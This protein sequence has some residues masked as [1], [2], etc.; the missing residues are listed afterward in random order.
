[1]VTLHLSEAKT[2][3]EVAA[4]TC[5]PEHPVYREGQGFVPAGRL[6]LGSQIVTRAGPALVVKGIEWGHQAGGYTVYNLMVE[7]DH[8]YFVGTANGGLWVH[9]T[10][11][12]MRDAFNKVRGDFWKNE[13]ETNPG[14]YSPSDLGRMKEGKAPIG[15]DGYP[16]ELHHRVPL[17][18]GG[19]NDFSNLDI[20][21]RTD[22]RLGPNYRINH[23]NVRT[24]R[25]G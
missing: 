25:R 12:E 22:H 23:P 9:N 1:M 24:G 21:T 4:L 5:T 20:M 15:S 18:N 13:G 14:A 2:G 6:A 11:P 16:M 19:T 3:Q 17:D 8:T 10:C 7:E